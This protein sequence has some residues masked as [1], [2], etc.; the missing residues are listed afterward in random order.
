[1]KN[2]DRN[3]LNEDRSP[4]LLWSIRI[5]AG[6]RAFGGESNE[7]LNMITLN[8]RIQIMVVLNLDAYLDHW[9]DLEQVKLKPIIVVKQPGRSC[10]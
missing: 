2:I 5:L 7:T 9:H 4:L 6:A 3:L 1:M 8:I 10:S